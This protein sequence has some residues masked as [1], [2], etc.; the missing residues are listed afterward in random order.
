MVEQLHARAQNFENQDP[1]K[2]RQ[3]PTGTHHP[4]LPGT[5]PGSLGYSLTYRWTTSG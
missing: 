5:V 1:Q 2:L 4:P 3:D